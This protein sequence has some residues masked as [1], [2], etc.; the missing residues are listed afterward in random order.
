M[1]ES[2]S[3]LLGGKGRA[4]AIAA[5]LA[6]LGGWRRWGLAFLCGVF[7]TLALPP[8]FFLPAL[9][10]AFP[11]FVWMLAGVTRR[12]SA[13]A[14]GWWFAFGYFAAGLYWMGFAMLVH[15]ARHAWLLPFASLG[16]PAFLALFGGLTAV[17]VVGG[18]THLERGLRLAIAWS[19]AEWLRGHILTGLPWNLV[20]HAWAGP[21]GLAQSAAVFGIYG[22]SL[23]AVMSACLLAALA[24]P[25]R[26]RM[27]G[28]VSVAGALLL[29][30]WLGGAW[31][32]AAAPPLGTDV[33]PNVGLR[34]VQAGVPQREKWRRD[35][36]ARN[37]NRHLDL[38]VRDRPAWVTHVIW[39]E[40]AATF[41]VD[42]RPELRQLIAR[43][44]PPGGALITGAPRRARDPLRIWNAM[45]VVDSAAA[46]IGRYE[47]FHLVPFG[48][49]VPFR[50][51]L[52][53]DKI[54]YGAID[55][56][57]GPGPRTLHIP[58]LPP[59]SPLICYEAIF[60]GAVI[61]DRD[62]PQWLLNL[63]NDGW[64]GHTAGPYQHLT[65]V[66][67]RAIE[68]GLPLVR[69]ANTGISAV[70]DSYGRTLARLGL[71]EKGVLDTRLSAPAAS[72]TLYSRYGDSL[73]FLCMVVVALVLVFATRIQFLRD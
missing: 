1:T 68:E 23:F 27:I 58:G 39:P 72:R 42:E 49:Y 53:L 32:I 63:T 35:L 36:R 25:G 60:P 61:D 16:M 24:D 41:Y 33:Q 56:S 31:R 62:R 73:Y 66:R 52:P 18:R 51:W 50:E 4:A 19:A 13:F 69:A 8:A 38:S 47:K 10:I 55:Y 29:L 12:R 20:G 26:R 67:M 34:I 17:V 30:P 45:F 70:F 9:Y 15:A 43:A 46:V 59:V 22:M 64:Y 48:E 3:G 6:A 7:V 28:A 54:A 5:R 40:N 57:A 2:G 71:A 37:F 21:D 11:V 14:L 44:L 65:L